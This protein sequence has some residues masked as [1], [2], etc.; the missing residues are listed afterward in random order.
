MHAPTEVAAW[1]VAEEEVA[2][3]ADL[4]ESFNAETW[5]TVKRTPKADDEGFDELSGIQAADDRGAQAV[6]KWGRHRVTELP[7]GDR[8]FKALEGQSNRVVEVRQQ[9]R[10]ILFLFKRSS[11]SS[12]Q[13]TVRM[14]SSEPWTAWC[15][16]RGGF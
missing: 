6:N 4:C 7:T 13:T 8:E 1:K 2:Y 12:T 3:T 5:I 11:Q 10:L 9:S 15:C 14:R 16:L